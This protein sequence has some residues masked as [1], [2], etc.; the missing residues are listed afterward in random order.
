M[1][2]LYKPTKHYHI[3]IINI[4]QVNMEIA[5]FMTDITYY[6]DVKLIKKPLKQRIKNMFKVFVIIAVVIGC[7]CVATYFSSALTVGDLS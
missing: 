1:N 4:S 2:I 7:F 3:G 6:N 5:N